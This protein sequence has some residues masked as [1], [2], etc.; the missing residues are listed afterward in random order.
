V[1]VVDDDPSLRE[2]VSTTLKLEGFETMTA[3]DGV[4]A[5]E[6]LTR[7]RFD[8]VILDAVMPRMDGLTVL[9]AIRSDPEIG[10]LP[11][12]MLSGLGEVH[13]LQRGVDAGASGYLTKPFDFRTLLEQLERLTIADAE[14]GGRG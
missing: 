5:L 13:H 10:D 1:L 4:M 8:V 7:C 3:A 11:V 14:V 9:R 2:L 6:L 12:L